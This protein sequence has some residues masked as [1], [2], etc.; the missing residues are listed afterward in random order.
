MSTSNNETVI[1]TSNKAIYVLNADFREVCTPFQVPQLEK[2][3]SA[4]M[5]LFCDDPALTLLPLWGRGL[6]VYKIAIGHALPI[7]LECQVPALGRK[8]ETTTI[9]FPLVV[10]PGRE[11]GNNFWR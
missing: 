5:E 3:I 9:K 10:P 8:I 7:A 6:R 4:V 1:P 2:I 11:Y